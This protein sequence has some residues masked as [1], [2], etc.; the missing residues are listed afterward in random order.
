MNEFSFFPGCSIP[1]GFPYYEKLV[2]MMLHEFDISVKYL[3]G[4]TC[5]PAPMSFDVFDDDT[6]YTIGAR[7]IALAEELGLDILSPC[8]GCT[9]TLS[10]VNKGLRSDEFL[11]QRVNDRLRDIG[12][13]YK[14]QVDV[15]SLL[16]TLFVDIGPDIIAERVRTPLKGLRVAIHY[17]C[18][19]FEELEEYNNVQNPTALETLCTSLGAEVIPY[20]FANECCLVFANTVDR[21]FVLNS[22]QKKMDSIRKAGANCIVV[23]C[24]SCLSQF[25]KTQE[26]FLWLDMMDEEDQLPVFLYPELMA[27]SMGKDIEEI[28]FFEHKVNVVPLLQSLGLVKLPNHEG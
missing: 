15:Q 10:R 11:R 19:A 1:S 18:H 12:K 16:K 25:D 3:D 7:N 14:G 9:M 23:I 6:F 27:L 24:A 28:G 13:Q 20:D 22:I 8:N 26:S 17:G 2:L 5:C 4:L 21:D